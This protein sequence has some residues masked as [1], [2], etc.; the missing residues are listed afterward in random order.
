MGTGDR[1]AKSVPSTRIIV[2][3]LVLRPF[4]RDDARELMEAIT[5]S[6]EHLRPWMPWIQFEPQDIHDKRKLIKEFSQEWDSRSGFPMGI[7]HGDHLVGASGYHVR[8]PEDSLEIGYWVRL[9]HTRKNIA[10]RTTRALIDEAFRLPEIARV[11]INHDQANM[12]SGRIPQSLGFTL[13]A[14]VE[15]EP[16]SPGDSGLLQQWVMTREAWLLKRLDQ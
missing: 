13:F 10:K 7:F 6:I 3:D 11:F 12:A 15:R 4:V 5:E 9:G 8:G 1:I 14:T 2:D 16:M